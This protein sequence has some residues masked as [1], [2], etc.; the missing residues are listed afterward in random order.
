M[1]TREKLNATAANLWWSW[2]P[3]AQDLFETLNPA[4]YL[5]SNRNPV[6]VL[7]SVDEAAISRV[8]GQVDRVYA[9]FQKYMTAAPRFGDAPRVSY[10]C[11]EYGLHESLPLY[12][13]GLGILAGD[14]AKSAS[15][16]GVPFVAIGLF[17][18]N[19]YFRQYFDHSGWQQEEYP[20]MNPADHPVTLVTDAK[21]EPI[22]I[23][24]HLGTVPL[25][26]QAWRV[27]IGRTTMYLLDADFHRN[28]YEYRELTGRLYQNGRA[29]RIQ[30]EIV[31]GIGGVRL[32]RALGI[33]TD[34]YHMNEGHCA[35]LTFELLRERLTSGNI[36]S[37]SSFAEA[38]TWVR[39]RC[40]FT[41]HTPVMAGHDRFDP[42]IFLEQME[43]FRHQLGFSGHDLLSYGRVYPN[44]VHEQF[45]M[46]V[47]AL[48]LARTSN[49]VSALHGEV[50]RRQWA[51]LFADRPVSQVP[52]GH[53]TNGVHLPTWTEPQAQA[54]LTK[55]LG[56]WRPH[57]ADADFWKRVQDI[58]DEALWALRTTL[59]HALIAGV[60]SHLKTHSIPAKSR[61]DPEALTIGFARRFAPYKRAGLLFHD[62]ES[63]VA[64]FAREDRPIQLIYAGKAHP[65]NDEGKQIIQQ[66]FEVAKHPAI[67]G[68]LI[69]MQDYSMATGRQLVAG[70][71]VWLN[72]PRRPYEA[73][74]TSGQKVTLH[75]GLNLSI[76]D[77]WWPEGFDGKNGW[78]IGHEASADPK[79]HAVQDREDVRFLH[80]VLLN[81]VIPMFY[82]RDEKGLPRQWI[83]FMRD[84]MT[85]LPAAFSAQ[86]MLIDY[87]EQIYRIPSAAK[88]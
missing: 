23:T 42:S 26:I 69:V 76:L 57:A 30:Q 66:L 4:V 33:E 58:P 36:L 52:I 2:N 6:A 13:G 21:G 86:R 12:A 37:D 24:V 85:T 11:M 59:R 68:R 7:R 14:H 41:T 77:G 50:A 63:A 34:V 70:C 87:I 18:R 28:P 10:F 78:A 67:A 79:D 54:F 40:V 56:D 81:E 84:A 82:D 9:D 61:L 65:A 47:L 46:T 88:A 44:D 31:L 60:D 17:L 55:H 22:T 73:S 64:L 1:T 71:D 45:T 83:Q 39:E 49:G 25:E 8:S 51:H 62:I 19:G 80:E 38:E 74:G 27:D 32:L 16:L 29:V 75:G 20:I 43:G 35:F 48:K 53:V 3:E 15:D 72:N 5:A